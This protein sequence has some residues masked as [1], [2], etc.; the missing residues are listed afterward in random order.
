MNWGMA[1]FKSVAVV[2]MVFVLRQHVEMAWWE[3]GVL[4]FGVMACF[5][6]KD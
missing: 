1:L 4:S 5:V 3:G 6:R 2:G